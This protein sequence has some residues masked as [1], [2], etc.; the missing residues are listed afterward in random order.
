VA[1]EYVYCPLMD[2]KVSLIT[3]EVQP[4]DE[5]R[6]ETYKTEVINGEVFILL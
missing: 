4:A 6:V 2:W 5:G 3:G 1:G